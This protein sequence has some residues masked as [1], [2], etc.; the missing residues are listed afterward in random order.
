M[1][2]DGIVLSKRVKTSGVKMT[3]M[4]LSLLLT[5]ASS[6]LMHSYA[7][8]RK[9]NIE[10]LLIFLEN[11]GILPLTERGG[12]Q[13]NKHLETSGSLVSLQVMLMVPQFTYTST[14]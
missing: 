9:P 2:E 4:K 1:E 11:T 13:V 3:V 5:K 12:I 7:T 6:V 8:G 14:R 10:P